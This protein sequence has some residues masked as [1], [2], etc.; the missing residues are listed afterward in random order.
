[1]SEKVV[2]GAEFLTEMLEAVSAEERVE[3]MDWLATVFCRHC[4]RRLEKGE[5]CQCN[6]DE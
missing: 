6:R 4:G 1:M 5:R 2:D 3:L